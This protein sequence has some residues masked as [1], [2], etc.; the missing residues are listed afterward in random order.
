[1]S[2]FPRFSQLI[3]ACL[4]IANGYFVGYALGLNLHGT[5]LNR[6]VASSIN[7]AQA[8]SAKPGAAATD[9]SGTPGKSADQGNGKGS[10]GSS[11]AAGDNASGDGSGKKGTS[12]AG[13]DTTS[14]GGKTK[15]SDSESVD[16]RLADS[17]QKASEAHLISNSADGLFHPDDPVTRAAFAR[18]LVQ[19]KQPPSAVPSKPTYADVSAGDPYYKDIESATTAH[20]MEGYSKKGEKRQF[21]PNEL[22]TREQFAQL[23]VNFSGKSSR[24][25]K[26]TD[27]E[28]KEGLRYDPDQTQTS[29]FGYKDEGE[30]DDWARPYVAVA[31]QAG[32]LDQ[33]FDCNPG[34][35]DEKKRFLHPQKKITRAEALNILIKLY[36]IAGGGNA[37][38]N[39]ESESTTKAAAEPAEKA[40]SSSQT[41]HS[42]GGN[43]TDKSN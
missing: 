42:A 20:L 12:N 2:S 39:S 41:A 40:D 22:I 14:G 35:V 30:I 38:S 10:A 4:V 1:M 34:S 16:S 31:Q 27:K 15:L 7:K 26:L 24:V 11:A 32:V 33:A 8:V 6:G 29:A 19:I 25:E 21:K 3:I 28:I 23:Y 43:K 36:G 37:D 9:S 5:R 18:W 13:A 17:L